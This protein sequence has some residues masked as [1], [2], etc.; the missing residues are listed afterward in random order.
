MLFEQFEKEIKNALNDKESGIERVKILALLYA[1]RSLTIIA[2]NAS[3]IKID[4][5]KR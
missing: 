3:R 5:I 2:D 1:V 4:D